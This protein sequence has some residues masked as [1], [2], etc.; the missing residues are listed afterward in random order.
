MSPRQTLY[1]AMNRVDPDASLFYA[2]KPTTGYALPLHDTVELPLWGYGG[3]AG[4]G[5]VSVGCGMR[6]GS[7]Q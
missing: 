3:E 1:D 6:N 5:T 7:R 2:I 4:P